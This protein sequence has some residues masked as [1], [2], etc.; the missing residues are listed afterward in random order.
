MVALDGIDGPLRSIDVE[1]DGAKPFFARR[2]IVGLLG[3][4]DL[5]EKTA[6]VVSLDESIEEVF[7]TLLDSTESNAVV[8]SPFGCLSRATGTGLVH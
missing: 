4:W 7:R 8:L 6:S 2:A 5:L 1:W 3:L